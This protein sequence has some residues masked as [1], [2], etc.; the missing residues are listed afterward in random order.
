MH[1]K[2]VMRL[3]APLMMPALRHMFS[4]RPAQLAAGLAASRTFAATA[5]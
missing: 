2:A 1:P 5:H 4:K 3:L